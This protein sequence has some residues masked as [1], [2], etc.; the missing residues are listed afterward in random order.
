MV[1]KARFYSKT[2]STSW[3]VDSAAERYCGETTVLFYWPMSANDIKKSDAF[4]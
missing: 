4:R 2:Y 3:R 1:N